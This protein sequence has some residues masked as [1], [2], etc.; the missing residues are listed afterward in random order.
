MRLKAE[1]AMPRRTAY[2]TRKMGKAFMPKRT[3]IGE[4]SSTLRDEHG[5]DEYVLIYL[6]LSLVLRVWYYY[7]IN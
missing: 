6:L 4:N 5:N 7:L 1:L 3:L 2:K